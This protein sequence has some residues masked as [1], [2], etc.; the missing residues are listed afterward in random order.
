[1]LRDDLAQ[2]FHNAVHAAQAAGALPAL[3]APVTFD[4]LHPK[5]TDHGD[6][7]CNAAMVIAAAARKAG[8]N[9]NPRQVAQLI[10]DYLPDSPIIATAEIAGP[11]FI[12]LR[13]AESW[14]QQ[15][16]D[17]IVEKGSRFGNSQRGA[18]Q[19]W[20]VEYVSANP[21]GPIHYGGARNAVLGESVARVLEAAGYEVQREYYVNDGGTQFQKFAETLYARY[22]RRLCHP[23]PRRSDCR[24]E[25]GWARSC[26]GRSERGT[27]PHWRCLR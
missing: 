7:S 3:D 23:A 19:R 13:L 2:L 24:H 1:M 25:R 16:V 21:T 11:G 26:A 17:T 22:M 14:L 15:Q 9:M 18:G 6:Y 8:A 10:L 27:R 20:Q 5:Q 12:N 4:V